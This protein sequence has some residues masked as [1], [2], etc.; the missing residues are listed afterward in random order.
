M[1]GFIIG[2]ALFGAI[3]SIFAAADKAELLFFF[4]V[5]ARCLELVL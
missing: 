2:L 4:A 3:D 1:M 5:A